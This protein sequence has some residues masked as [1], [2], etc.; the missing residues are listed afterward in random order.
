MDL[1]ALYFGTFHLN[2]SW[3]GEDITYHGINTLRMWLLK[4]PPETAFIC[5]VLTGG[6]L[7]N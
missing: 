2:N 7:S 5:G 4:N 3:T 1:G 6:M